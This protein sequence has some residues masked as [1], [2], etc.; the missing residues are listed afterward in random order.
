M[1]PASISRDIVAIVILDTISGKHYFVRIG[2]SVRF[3]PE[4]PV[5]S[6][7]H[8]CLQIA[9]YYTIWF[10]PGRESEI[11]AQGRLGLRDS[12]YL[13]IDSVKLVCSFSIKTSG[14]VP[15]QSTLVRTIVSRS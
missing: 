2:T 10:D 14:R 7:G 3:N 4:I 8:N 12:K 15:Y 5:C 9:A 11:I 1:I 13:I 6:M